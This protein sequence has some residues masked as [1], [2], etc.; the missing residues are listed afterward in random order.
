MGFERAFRHRSYRKI[1]TKRELLISVGEIRQPRAFP[2]RKIA[3][4]PVL[5]IEPTQGKIGRQPLADPA[6]GVEIV[7]RAQTLL[8]LRHTPREM[9]FNQLADE[10]RRSHQV[11]RE[12]QQLIGHGAKRRAE[13]AF[14]HHDHETGLR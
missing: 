4:R 11:A 3:P 5:C 10:P 14:M 12:K 13:I 6:R 2:G 9:E 8:L 7:R 1:R